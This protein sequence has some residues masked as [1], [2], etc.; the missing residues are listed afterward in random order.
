MFRNNIKNMNYLTESSIKDW[1]NI[2][3]NNVKC[4]ELEIEGGLTEEQPNIF[5]NKFIS[6]GVTTTAV[7]PTPSRILKN[8]SFTGGNTLN[9]LTLITDVNQYYGVA[10][11]TPGIYR[12]NYT[13]RF[14]PSV[15]TLSL[16]IL[17]VLD[18]IAPVLE[19]ETN[20]SVLYTGLPGGKRE[21]AIM[22]GL[23]EVQ[24]AAILWIR[25][26]ANT[27]VSLST[28]YNNLSVERVSD[29]P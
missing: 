19:I 28:E 13:Y 29:I 23:V 8:L 7:G 21:V 2:N 25:A 12:V 17:C 16:R 3:A 11:P 24:S 4:K 15:S 9:E 22:S 18:Q 14:V 1:M 20:L 5:I 27:A 26:S 6:G 10:I